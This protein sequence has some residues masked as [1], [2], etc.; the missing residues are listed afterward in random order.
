MKCLLLC[1]GKGE[2]LRPITFEVHK[3]MIPIYGFPLLTHIIN[4]YQQH[5]INDF[6]I[7]TGVE[8]YEPISRRYNGNRIWLEKSKLDTGGWLNTNLGKSLMS[9]EE[10]VFV[11][12]GDNLIDLS[13]IDLL[14]KH[15][16]L[17]T[18]VTIACVKVKDI[19]QYGTVHVKD[20]KIKEF[21]EKK[22][23]RKRQSGWV[24]SGYYVFNMDLVRSFLKESGLDKKKSLSLERDLFPALAKKG[25]LGA[26]Q[27]TA[28]WFDVGDVDK[29][30]EV[31]HKW[32]RVPKPFVLRTK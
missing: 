16:S 2:R 3:S 19:S 9:N 5:G 4:K 31:I 29:Y 32:K 12:N 11:N 18:A 24:S 7:I 30:S 21:L 6:D 17:K 20:S 25:L 15:K 8:G 26:Y 23:S 13:F 1:G 28:D 27:T 14:C 22:K 10:N